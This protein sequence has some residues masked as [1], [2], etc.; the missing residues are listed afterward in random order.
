VLKRAGVKFGN[1]CGWNG[2]RPRIANLGS[3]EFGDDVQIRG[4]NKPISIV[5]TKTGVIKIGDRVFIN[6]AVFIYSNSAISIG[7]ACLIGNGCYISDYSFHAVHCDRDPT[8]RPIVIGRN[9][10]LGEGAVILPGITIGDHSVIAARSVV[11]DD[12]PASQVWRGNPAT[13][14]KN[15]RSR[16]GFE[17]L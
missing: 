13:F 14:F 12:V 6:S 15:V 16:D 11:F 7:P 17:R 4:T 9:V 3:I 1:N 2:A 10:W 8:S 5:T